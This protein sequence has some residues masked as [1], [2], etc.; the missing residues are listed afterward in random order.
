MPQPTPNKK[1]AKSIK[2]NLA[3]QIAEAFEGP[4]RVFRFECVTGDKD[5]PTD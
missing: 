4:V 5:H 2:V 1:I 3:L